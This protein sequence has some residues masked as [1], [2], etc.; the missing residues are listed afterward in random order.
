MTS[1]RVLD[2]VKR[3]PKPRIRLFLF[4]AAEIVRDRVAEGDGGGARIHV[5]ARHRHPGVDAPHPRFSIRRG[6]A[7]DSDPADEY[8]ETKHKAASL[9]RCMG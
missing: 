5:S 3:G 2:R 1:R 9:V 4:G 8:L 6:I 7:W